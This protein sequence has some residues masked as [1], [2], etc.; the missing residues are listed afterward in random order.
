LDSTQARPA[1]PGLARVGNWV[2]RFS[3]ARLGLP[4]DEQEN[5]P[6]WFL[7]P[8]M[9]VLVNSAQK[10]LILVWT[11][12]K[13]IQIYFL[14]VLMPGISRWI[15]LHLWAHFSI[16]SSFNLNRITP[17]PQTNQ[18]QSRDR[19]GEAGGNDRDSR[20]WPRGQS[21]SVNCKNF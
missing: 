7:T 13:L 12:N 3:H 8:T 6:S 20:R 5:Q 2:G 1:K 21:D 17:T 4:D 16:N 19:K 11:P 18:E 14:I 10:P 15:L 9:L